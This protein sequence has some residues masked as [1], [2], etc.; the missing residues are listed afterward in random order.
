MTRWLCVGGEGWGG[1]V[2]ELKEVKEVAMTAVAQYGGA[3]QWASNE[4]Q[5]DKEVAMAAVA[6]N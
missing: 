4:L 1:G 5:E 3:L 6:Q 2:D